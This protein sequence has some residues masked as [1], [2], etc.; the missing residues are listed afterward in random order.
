MDE[1]KRARLEAA[2]WKFGDAADFLGLTD[3]ERKLVD[4]RIS[5][6]RAIR[7]RREAAGLTQAAAAKLIKTGQS[8]FAKIEMGLP[9]GVSLDLMIRAYFALGGQVEELGS[10]G[11][12]RVVKA[13]EAR[14]KAKDR[15]A[16]RE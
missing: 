15:G 1:A 8:R 12:P 14:G 16:Y 2:G 10:P 5:L 4:F 13:T 6:S 9:S 3:E 7:A 11:A